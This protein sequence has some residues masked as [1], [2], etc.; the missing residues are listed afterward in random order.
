MEIENDKIY[1]HKQNK[2]KVKIIKV[3]HLDNKV[4]FERT[5]YPRQRKTVTSKQFR[6]R[7]KPE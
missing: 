4:T 7:Y 5:E 6:Q 2:V 1:I 3:D